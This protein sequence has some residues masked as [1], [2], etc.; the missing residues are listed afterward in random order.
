MGTI[1]QSV[2]RDLLRW[3]E[4][5]GDETAL[6]LD[7]LPPERRAAIDFALMSLWIVVLVVFGAVVSGALEVSSIR[8]IY[9]HVLY[10]TRIL[11]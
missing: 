2:S 9:K 1:A 3:R 11:G 4:S 6:K 5:I 7:K 8:E 10:S